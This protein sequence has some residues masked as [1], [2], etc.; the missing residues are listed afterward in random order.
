MRNLL[1]LPKISLKRFYMYRLFTPGLLLLL[2]FIKPAFGQPCNGAA[3][4]C[5][6]TQTSTATPLPTGGQYSGGTVVTFCYTMVDYSQC[7]SNWFHTLDIDLGPGWDVST[8]MPISWPASCDGLGIWG[9]YNS[10][11]GLTE[12]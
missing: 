10:V 3:W 4:Q 2:F 6:G 1:N 9:Y 12:K 5:L 8:F 7:N 11:T